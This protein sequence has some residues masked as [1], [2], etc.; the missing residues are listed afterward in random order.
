MAAENIMPWLTP[1]EVD[2]KPVYI[3]NTEIADAPALLKQSTSLDEEAP[4]EVRPFT[5]GEKLTEREYTEARAQY[6]QLERAFKVERQETERYYVTAVY[7]SEC[8]LKAG[9]EL[10]QDA[11]AR[12]HRRF[13]GFDAQKLRHRVTRVHHPDCTLKPGASAY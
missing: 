11:L 2:S 1:F 5:V 3:M 9:E 12:A 8:P 13:T 7:H 4:S 6:K 10:T